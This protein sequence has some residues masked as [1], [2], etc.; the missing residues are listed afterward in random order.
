MPR[1]GQSAVWYNI[2]I[3]DLIDRMTPMEYVPI[4]PLHGT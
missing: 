1:I 3:S 4:K 2:I